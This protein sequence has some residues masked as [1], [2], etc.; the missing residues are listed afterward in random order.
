MKSKAGSS[1]PDIRLHGAQLSAMRQLFRG[2]E[3]PWQK[4]KFLVRS[5]AAYSLHLHYSPPAPASLQRFPPGKQ[6]A[7]QDHS[8]DQV[9]LTRW[10]RPWTLFAAP[11][12]ATWDPW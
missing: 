4:R 3:C 10:F 7:N 9:A 1:A 11:P 12:S 2:P 8:A 5:V 6:K